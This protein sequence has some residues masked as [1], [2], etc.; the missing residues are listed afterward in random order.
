LRELVETVNGVF[1]RTELG[2]REGASFEAF[3]LALDQFEVLLLELAT[4]A[5]ELAF[6]F[7]HL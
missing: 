3:P 6:L 5:E 7:G 2:L 1:V 4:G